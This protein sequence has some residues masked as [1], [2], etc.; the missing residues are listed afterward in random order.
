LSLIAATL[1][2][3]S[4]ALAQPQGQVGANQ[5]EEW[6]PT[7]FQYGIETQATNNGLSWEITGKTV[8]TQHEP[9]YR[10][11][12]LPHSER[13]TQVSFDYTVRGTPNGTVRLEL[14]DGLGDDRFWNT[15]ISGTESDSV[16]VNLDGLN[17][18]EFRL[19]PIKQSLRPGAVVEVTNVEV[20]S[21]GV[22]SN[23]INS[24]RDNVANRFMRSAMA[25][26]PHQNL[27]HHAWPDSSLKVKP[28]AADDSQCV[29]EV[30]KLDV[31]ECLRLKGSGYLQLQ[32]QAS[33]AAGL[34]RRSLPDIEGDIV[35]LGE[36][37]DYMQA[38]AAPVG[39]KNKYYYIHGKA[40]VSVPQ[41]D[42]NYSLS[43]TRMDFAT[44]LDGMERV[45]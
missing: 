19:A 35:A 3:S 17:G 26:L 41:S 42:A 40:T 36:G 14:W 22:D 44:V 25:R 31:G 5:Y 12:A 10:G 37:G 13:I 45:F 24:E 7:G 6:I 39:M 33:N 18:I 11:F 43:V 9:L 27:P 30:A 29:D 8:S 21:E 4:V 16:D 34:A 28:N 20:Q 1:T 2:A 23:T 38:N 32:W 15:K